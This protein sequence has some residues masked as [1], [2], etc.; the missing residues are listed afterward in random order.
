[1]IPWLSEHNHDFPNVSNA[2]NE[3]NGL[4]AAG[5]DLSPTRLIAAYKK[6]IFP[7][8][9]DPD[10]I[11]WWS[12]APRCVMPIDQLHISKSLKKTIKKKQFSVTFDKAFS[13]VI[14]QCSLSRKDQEGTWI[15]DDIQSAYL[16]LHHMGIAHSV[17]VWDQNIL[18]GG[19]YGIALGNVFFGESMFSKRDNSSKIAFCFLVNQLR[20]WHFKVIDCQ[21]HS[22][23]LQSLGAIEID[24]KCFLDYLANQDKNPTLAPNGYWNLSILA[25]DIC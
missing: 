24:R 16:Q 2:L 6:G 8:Y 5:G 15:T 22:P 14:H 3:P 19:L 25:E 12:P 13:Q 9:S 21:V 1:M 10:P 7:W 11:L 23:H 18:V 17:E 20:S 4:L